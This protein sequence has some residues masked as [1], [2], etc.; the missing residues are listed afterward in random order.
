MD[1]GGKTWLVLGLARS[2]VAAAGLL[3]RR[4]AAV[5]G[6][7]DAEP[8]RISA[9]WKR[10]HLDDARDGRFAGLCLGGDTRG[11]PDDFDGLVVSPGVPP[12]HPL[13][14]RC[15]DRIPVI[16]EMELAA[17][18]FDGPLIA[19]TG[20]NGKTT[21]TELTAHLLREAG[22]G[23]VALGNLG[24]P[25]SEVADRLEPG[26]VAVLEVSSF[27]LETIRDFA[28]DV[29]AILNLAPDHLDR[30]PDLDAYYE[31]KGALVRALGQ[32]GLFVAMAGD[33]AAR[34][35]RASAPV[36][37]GDPESGATVFV[38]DGALWRE[39]DGETERIIALGEM[40][41]SGAPNHLNAA[42][43]VACLERFDIPAARLADGLRSF[44]GLAHRQ[45]I[46]GRRGDL[47]FVN[48]SK[49]T[50]VHAV[51][52]GLAG[53][54]SDVVIILGGSG[55]G[56][57]YAPLR[58]ASAPL[59][60][61]VLIGREAD[62]IAAALDGAVP[63]SRADS[64]D[65]AVEIAAREAAPAGF[66]LMSPACASFDMFADYTARGEAFRRAV[67]T[68]IGTGETP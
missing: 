17:R 19:I 14:R 67:A 65:A 33:E 68:L 38:K 24:R 50:N 26:T 46:V 4:G 51:C 15:G 10:H 12:T 16:G 43:A 18:V 25:F 42:A 22:T 28:P 5:F 61:A 57:D 9:L 60:H 13:I 20:T 29:G 34:R 56:E 36:L 32:E 2:G 54:D 41:I 64:L 8:E 27:Q 7:D 3:R 6:V 55:K 40:G 47:V 49:A 59:R 39:R 52:S 63:M 21:T 58:A 35:W 44:R 48:D 45:E 66:V 31:M 53:Y 11:L 37:F 1:L 62:R 23:A 30:Y